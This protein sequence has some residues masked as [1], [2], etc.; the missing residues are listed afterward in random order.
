MSPD[1]YSSLCVCPN[2]LPEFTQVSPVSK[3]EALWTAAAETELHRLSLPE[4]LC[5]Q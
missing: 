3:G 5:D 2:E 4:E 1:A